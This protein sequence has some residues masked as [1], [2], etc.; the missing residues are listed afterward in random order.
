MRCGGTLI[1]DRYVL[2]A[3]HCTVT[4]DKYAFENNIINDTNF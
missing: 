3:A 2:T 1:S 4:R